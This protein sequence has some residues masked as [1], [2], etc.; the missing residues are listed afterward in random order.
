MYNSLASPSERSHSTVNDSPEAATLSWDVK[1]TPV[2]V[3][4]FKPTATL[5]VDST[6]TPSAKLTALEDILYGTASSTPRLPYPDE[7][8][9]LIGEAGTTTGVTVIPSEATIAVG[10]TFALG[11]SAVPRTA[12][13]TWTS[14]AP[15]KATV[16]ESGIV[17]GVEAGSATITA[18]ITVDETDYTDT[19]AI[20]IE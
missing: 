1:T 16:N 2:N 20:T 17:T 7:V 5:E 19:C 15:G 10:D 4:G 11:A 9:A 3:I 18:T 14:S 13:I 8:I 12:A 6:K